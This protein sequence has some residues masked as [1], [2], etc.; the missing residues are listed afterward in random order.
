LE[1]AAERM[2]TT[3]EWTTLCDISYDL[4]EKKMNN[5][6]KI[7]EKELFEKDFPIVKMYLITDV[8]VFKW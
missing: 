1:A 7:G 4:P 3:M 6:K 2:I 8:N 5:S